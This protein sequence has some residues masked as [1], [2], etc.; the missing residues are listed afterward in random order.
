MVAR[1]A[2]PL[3]TKLLYGVGQAAESIKNFG[4]GTLLLLYYNQVLGL[5]GTYCGIAVFIAIAADAISDPVVGSWSDGIQ[6]RWGRRH[7]FM[8]VSIL[9]LGLTF[10]FLF[11]PPQGL[12][13]FSLFVWFATA[14]VLVRTALTFFHVPY[15]SMGA[16]LTQDY[17]E[18]TRIVVVRTA[19]GL[20]A[21]LAVIAI[22][23][24]YFFI[25]S[26]DNLTPQLTREP[27]FSYAFLSSAVMMVMMLICVWGTRHSISTLA[28]SKQVA[29]RFNFMQVYT[30]IYQA[31]QNPSYRALFFS[32]I[33][34]FIFAGTHGA[35]AMHLKTFFW[36]LDTRG[37]QYWQYGAVLGGILG[38]PLTPLLNRWVDKKWTVII[39]CGGA[40]LANTGPVLMKMAGLMPTDMSVLVP[41]LVSLSA[42]STI[43]A[44]QAGVTVASMMGDIADEHELNHGTRQEG[45]YFGSY[46]FSAKC[47]T[48]VGNLVAGFAL[49]IIHFPVNSKPGMVD[50]S[51][52]FDFGVMYSSVTLIMIFSTWVFLSYRLDRK[53]HEEIMLE[54]EKRQ[55]THPDDSRLQ[56]EGEMTKNP[57]S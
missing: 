56:E 35:L 52:L 8:L 20:A 43:S 17:Q 28:G 21:A 36:Q 50:E 14:S 33:L 7:P 15:L 10:Y 31:L 22:A 9:P 1:N 16:E 11:V 55:E 48:A 45:I 4:F 24:N 40:A 18:R 27:Y 57:A 47:T 39:G 5:S 13:E 42:F 54:L 32:T 30:D 3:N 37:I 44:L 26:P 6:S 19:F 29:R 25:S 38:L 46:N 12:S 49:D 53:R 51:V 41:I 34:F 23:W 2:V